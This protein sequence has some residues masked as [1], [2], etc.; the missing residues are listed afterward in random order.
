MIKRLLA[1]STLLI[2]GAVNAAVF[3]TSRTN[4]GLTLTNDAQAT[5]HC[6]A[7]YWQNG[8]VTWDFTISPHS[9][10][11]LLRWT[12]AGELRQWRCRY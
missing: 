3:E 7:S 6:Q 12:A 10:Y 4:T 9:S 11:R 1:A 8:M 5:A 2:A